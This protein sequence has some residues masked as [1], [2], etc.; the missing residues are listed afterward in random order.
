[1]SLFLPTA[2]GAIREQAHASLF[3]AGLGRKYYATGI[4]IREGNRPVGHEKSGKC[5]G[6]SF[7]IINAFLTL[8]AVTKW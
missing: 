8:T 4:D 5:D 3:L 7:P 1:L 2:V 6:N